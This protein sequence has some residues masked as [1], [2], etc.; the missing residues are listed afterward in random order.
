MGIGEILG[1]IGVAVSLVGIPITFFVARRTRQAPELQYAIDFDVLVA[2]EDQQLLPSV[3][4]TASGEEITSLSRTRIAVWNKK[5]D[6]IH[7]H[8]ILGE[9]PLRV[10]L[11]SSDHLVQAR[12]VS[13]SRWQIDPRLR[14][15]PDAAPHAVG[16]EFSFLDPGD[17]AIVEL[18][19]QDTTEPKLMGTIQGASITY[20]GTASLSADALAAAETANRL[21]RL[22]KIPKR[23][24]AIAL[25]ITSLVLVAQGIFLFITG[26]QGLNKLERTPAIVNPT[27]FHLDTLKGQAEFASKVK[28]VGRPDSDTWVV[29]A[30]S[31]GVGVF[32]IA[33]AVSQ[34]LLITRAVIPRSILQGEARQESFIQLPANSSSLPS[35]PDR[36]RDLTDTSA[37]AEGERQ[38]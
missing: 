30:L 6:T 11:A 36:G 3:V 9:D 29:P 17:G 7:A 28:K 32:A 1:A 12:I 10:E 20:K 34:F 31:L 21:R 37:G 22:G 18:I 35:H 5:G 38:P 15:E 23:K 24:R 25:I 13:Y 16:I 19:H 27:E 14:I 4:V 33:L 8:Q 2:A 26:I